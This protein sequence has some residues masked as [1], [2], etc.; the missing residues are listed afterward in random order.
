MLLDILSR[1]AGRVI[2][3]TI[4][5]DYRGVGIGHRLLFPCMCYSVPLSWRLVQK[6]TTLLRSLA[7]LFCCTDAKE[8][9]AGSAADIA[10]VSAVHAYIVGLNAVSR[11]VLNIALRNFVSKR[12]KEML[13]TTSGRDPF[14][15]AFFSERFSKTTLPSCIGGTRASLDACGHCCVNEPL[16]ALTDPNAIFKLWIERAGGMKSTSRRSSLHVDIVD[17]DA[18]KDQEGADAE[19]VDFLRVE[20]DVVRASAKSPHRTP[21]ALHCI[22]LH[23]R[24]CTLRADRAVGAEGAPQRDGRYQ[25]IQRRRRRASVRQYAGCSTP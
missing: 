13:K 12:Q 1:K 8:F 3:F 18:A 15:F 9:A 14:K 10:P 23:R 5:I 11:S 25:T 4:L 20:L 21:H 2:D 6:I 16:P 19:G 17:G 22:R 7:R 24:A